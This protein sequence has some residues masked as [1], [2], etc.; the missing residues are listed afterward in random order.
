MPREGSGQREAFLMYFDLLDSSRV[1]HCSMTCGVHMALWSEKVRALQSAQ[2]KGSVVGAR[3]D[4]CC[5][6]FS[7]VC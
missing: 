7:V 3:M 4:L 2:A 6:Q 5:V 1:H